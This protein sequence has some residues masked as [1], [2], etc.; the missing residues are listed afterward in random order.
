LPHFFPSTTHRHRCVL[1]GGGGRRARVLCVKMCM[2]VVFVV[3]GLVIESRRI[4]NFVSGLSIVTAG[5]Q[6]VWVLLYSLTIGTTRSMLSII[7]VRSLLAFPLQLFFWRHIVLRNKYRYVEYRRKFC[8]VSSCA[9]GPTIELWVCIELRVGRRFVEELLLQP[10]KSS[11]HDSIQ[12]HILR[13]EV[14][15]CWQILEPEFFCSYLPLRWKNACDRRHINLAAVWWSTFF[16]RIIA[17]KEQ[18]KKLSHCKGQ[19]ALL[20]ET[21]CNQRNTSFCHL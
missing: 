15:C 19:A 6:L 4:C 20:E 10:W 9:S 13:F 2:K 18:E 16:G 12:V 7:A 21:K 17:T 11:F 1:G 5:M 8:F 14:C 3:V